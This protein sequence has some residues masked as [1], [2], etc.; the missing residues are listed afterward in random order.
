M[1]SNKRAKVA[2]AI[3]HNFQ[4]SKNVM[5]CHTEI[6]QYCM[7]EVESPCETF[8]ILMWWRV[9][10]S[11]FHVLAEITWDVLAIPLTFVASES[12]FSI[13]GRIIDHFRSSLA[14]K[15]VEALICCQNWLRSSPNFEYGIGESLLPDIEDEES[16]KLELGSIC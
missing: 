14:S 4:A 13:G 8:N 11:K 5:W 10:K 6:E 7:E 2:L 9:N 3:Y 12:T 16:Y 1:G 15:T